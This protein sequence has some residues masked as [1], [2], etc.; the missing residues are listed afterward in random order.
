M[1]LNLSYYVKTVNFQAVSVSACYALLSSVVVLHFIS[2]PAFFIYIFR[3]IP[4]FYVCFFFY[5]A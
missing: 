3:Q 2:P 5:L 4:P 1:P